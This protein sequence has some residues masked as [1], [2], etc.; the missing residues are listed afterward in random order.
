MRLGFSPWVR[1]IPW[2]RAWQPTPVFLPGEFHEQRNLVGYSPRGS[3][4]SDM[5]EAT[6]HTRTADRGEH[7]SEKPLWF[8][9]AYIGGLRRSRLQV[10]IISFLS[11][12]LHFFFPFPSFLSFLSFF[13]SFSSSAIM[14]MQLE[15][16]VLKSSQGCFNMGYHYTQF[17]ATSKSIQQTCC[18]KK[19]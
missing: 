17:K 10:P 9:V 14:W 7:S 15:K 1:K 12:L 6:Q 11:F 18:L 19:I 8:G 5:T 13:L 4:D 2:R 16:S 3:K